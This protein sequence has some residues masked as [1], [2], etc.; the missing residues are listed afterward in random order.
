MA[1][2]CYALVSA[3]GEILRTTE[4]LEL[5]PAPVVGADNVLVGVWQQCPDDAP[6]HNP[7]L[8]ETHSP[9]FVLRGHRVLREF[10]IR[11]KS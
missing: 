4:P 3:A 5:P 2:H 1:L 8:H 7:D 10:Q 11:R 6:A 9:R